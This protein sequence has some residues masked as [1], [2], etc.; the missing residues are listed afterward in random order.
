MV[1]PSH[2]RAAEPLRLV[3]ATFAADDGPL[4]DVANADDVG[5]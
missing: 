5:T 4:L 2:A 1:A 3:F